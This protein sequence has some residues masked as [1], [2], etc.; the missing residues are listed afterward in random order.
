MNFIP[1]LGE[2][3]GRAEILACHGAIRR[4]GRKTSRGGIEPKE[5]HRG[6]TIVM[7]LWPLKLLCAC[8]VAAVHVDAL[9]AQRWHP[10]LGLSSDYVVRG[11]SQS[12]GRASAQAG[13]SCTSAQGVYAGTWSS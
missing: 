2:L 13:L 10:S 9:A 11:I 8:C 6:L 3:A 7:S 4:G 1:S 5:R 12:Q